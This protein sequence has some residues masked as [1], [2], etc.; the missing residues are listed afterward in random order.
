MFRY[1]YNL[2][3]TH[4]IIV[5]A[6]ISGWQH[7]SKTLAGKQLI[8]LGLVLINDINPDEELSKMQKPHEVA[9]AL[10]LTLYIF[11]FNMSYIY[12]FLRNR[13]TFASHLMQVKC[14]LL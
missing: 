12:I 6:N 9:H 5:G 11:I 13:T 7:F 8:A 3:I 2:F 1:S 10:Y 14:L 4:L